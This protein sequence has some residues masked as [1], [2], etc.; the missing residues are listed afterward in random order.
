MQT[1]H[2]I[3]ID[4][5]LL[6]RRA[7]PDNHIGFFGR[8]A[9]K[10]ILHHQKVQLRKGLVTFV[11]IGVD[12]ADILAHIE[13]CLDL[14]FQHRIDQLRGHQPNIFRCFIVGVII[15]Q[16]SHITRTLHVVLST[17][18]HQPRTGLADIARQ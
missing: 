2:R 9:H 15:G 14:A 13:Q 11:D 6:I 17:Q 8:L 3:D 5:G 18:R 10:E 16:T 1:A 7:H 12:M 4:T